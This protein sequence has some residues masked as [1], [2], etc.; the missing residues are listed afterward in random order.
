MLSNE[1]EG[2]WKELVVACLRYY[3]IIYLNALS[4]VMINLSQNSQPRPRFEPEICMWISSATFLTE[5]FSISWALQAFQ[6][7]EVDICKWWV[8]KNWVIYSATVGHSTR[9][10]L[11][12]EDEGIMI[13]QNVRNCLISGTVTSSKT[14][15][16]DTWE[17]H[18]FVNSLC[19]LHL[20]TTKLL[21]PFINF[22]LRQKS[23]CR[24]WEIIFWM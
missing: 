11:D 22:S 10:L 16:V 6:H 9:G 23:W 12:S 24:W 1:L 13:I 19:A 20:F 7:L 2:M 17:V 3:P 5:M 18:N 8:L 14:W 15:I 21:N 4:T